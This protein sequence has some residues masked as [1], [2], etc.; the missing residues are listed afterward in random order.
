[1]PLPLRDARGHLRT[2][3]GLLD[4]RRKARRGPD[5]RGTDPQLDRPTPCAGLDVRGLLSHLDGLALA[6]T[7][8]GA[9]DFGELTDTAPDPAAPAVLDGGWRERIPARLR[10]LAETWRDPA[11]WTGTTRAGGVDL[12]GEVA[13]LVALDEVV[14]HGWDVAVATGQPYEPD[15][16]STAVVHGFLTES[17][18]ED[19]PESLFGPVVAVREDAPL[20]HRALGLAGRDPSWRA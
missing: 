9:K 12:P 5:Q 20:F 18:T 6:F 10:A 7:A 19:V 17:R 1:M 8:A 14:L 2:A 4:G 15:E 3:G 13:G 16:Q 11:A